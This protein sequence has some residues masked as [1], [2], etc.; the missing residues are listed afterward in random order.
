MN[1]FIQLV[2]E[3]LMAY[4]ESIKSIKRIKLKDFLYR[5][6]K[7]PG[8]K[9]TTWMRIS[10][11]LNNYKALKVF[12]F[13]ARLL[14]RHYQVKYGIQIG[15]RLAVKGGFCINHYGGIVI[16]ESAQIGKNFDIRHNLTIGHV[17]GESP[18]IGD[19][20]SCGP[21]VII[22][23]KVHIGNNVLIGAGTIVVKDIPS[24]SVV[25]GNPGKVIKKID[26]TKKAKI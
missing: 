12:Y 26:P 8:F 11:Y 21:G 17:N 4:D 20:V 2:K 25:V 5:Y 7:T 15:F 6:I 23:G 3:D 13:L 22:I 10:N 19:N 18:I 16:G 9:V 24:N 1:E 14:Y